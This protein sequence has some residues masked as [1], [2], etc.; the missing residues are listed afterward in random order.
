MTVKCVIVRPPTGEWFPD[1]LLTVDHLWWEG[2]SCSIDIH[3]Y[4][5]VVMATLVLLEYVPC[6]Q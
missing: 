6:D 3:I 4:C 2:P 1:L 5:N